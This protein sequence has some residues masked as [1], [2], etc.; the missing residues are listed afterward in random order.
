[1]SIIYVITAEGINSTR[2][3]EHI[4]RKYDRNTDG[5]R[6]IKDALARIYKL[7]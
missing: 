6:E 2:L 7:N 5:D 1:M 3:A 4:G